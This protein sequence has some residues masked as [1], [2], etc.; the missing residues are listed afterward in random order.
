MSSRDAY[1][2]AADG[3][4]DTHAMPGAYETLVRHPQLCYGNHS[5]PDSRNSSATRPLPP[6]SSRSNGGRSP[7]VLRA[8]GTKKQRKTLNGR[9]LDRHNQLY[10]N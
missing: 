10:M 2:V 8:Y 6:V 7:G 3:T 5:A 4:I 1:T 9:P